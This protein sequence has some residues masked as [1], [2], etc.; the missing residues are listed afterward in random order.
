MPPVTSALCYDAPAVVLSLAPCPVDQASPRGGVLRAARRPEGW[1]AQGPAPQLPDQ[2]DELWPG[3]NE[4]LCWLAGNWRILQRQDGH[5]TSLDD[6]LTA[7]LAATM[8]T[9]R[10]P[11]RCLDLGCGIGSVLLFLAWRFPSAQLLGIEAQDVSAALA[12]RSLGW[13]GI[14]PRAEIRLGDFRHATIEGQ[15]DV[16]TGTPPYFPVGSGPQSEGVQRA[17]CRFEHRG[18]IEAYCAAAAPLLAD[19]APFVAC[20]AW[21]QRERVAPAAEAAGLRLV[22]WRDVVPRTGKTPLLC[23][24]ATRRADR[25]EPLSEDP[26]LVV[27]DEKG[28]RSEEFCQIRAAMG[29]P[30]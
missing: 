10:P 23:V 11:A 13:N 7:H 5:R 15:F 29:M 4:D 14:A 24:F 3:P 19:G 28:R 27:R 1:V 17:P 26:P 20:E 18:G 6:L 30:W 2:L 22:R 16:V 12:V 8:V 21:S 9:E 25:A